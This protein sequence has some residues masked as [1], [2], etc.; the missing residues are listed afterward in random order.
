MAEPRKLKSKRVKRILNV[1]RNPEPG[2]SNPGPKSKKKQDGAK[3]RLKTSSKSGGGF[4]N[5]QKAPPNEVQL[6]ESSSD[7]FDDY[8][9]EVD[10]T[11]LAAIDIEAFGDGA[12]ESKTKESANVKGK[13]KSSKKSSKGKC[14]K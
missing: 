9:D 10:D 13:G 3:H 2:V 4:V 5:Q 1:I 6:S 12:Q 11:A 8:E 7:E 14:K